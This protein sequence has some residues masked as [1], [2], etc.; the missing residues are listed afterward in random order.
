M[1]FFFL[2]LDCLTNLSKP[3]KL[4]G[5][6]YSC[7]KCKGRQNATKKVTITELP[8]VLVLHVN[9]I[10]WK[11]VTRQKIQTMVDFPLDDL[12]LAAHST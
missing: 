2:I 10:K 9:R 1:F 3:E 12:D 6:S 5:H 8:D 4:E 7:E 11:G